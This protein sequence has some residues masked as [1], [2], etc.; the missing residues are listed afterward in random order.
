MSGNSAEGRFSKFWRFTKLTWDGLW[1]FTFKPFHILNQSLVRSLVGDAEDPRLIHCVSYALTGEVVDSWEALR[2]ELPEAAQVQ[3]DTAAIF[4]AEITKRQA[5]LSE[6]YSKLSSDEIRSSPNN[7]LGELALSLFKDLFDARVNGENQHIIT[8]RSGISDDQLKLS[9]A[10]MS[11][12]VGYTV[13]LQKFRHKT[14]RKE[15]WN[16]IRSLFNSKYALL[17]ELSDIEKN[18]LIPILKPAFTDWLLHLKVPQEII[19]EIFSPNVSTLMDETGKP[20][21]QVQLRAATERLLKQNHPEAY[22]L[23]QNFSDSYQESNVPF[24]GWLLRLSQFLIVLL[25]AQ[26][27]KD[28]PLF[29]QALAKSFNEN[30]EQLDD[31][32][33]RLGQVMETLSQIIRYDNQKQLYPLG[34]FGNDVEMLKLLTQADQQKI[35]PPMLKKSVNLIHFVRDL[36]KARREVFSGS[37]APGKPEIKPL[38]FEE[39]CVTFM[40]KIPQIATKGKADWVEFCTE[41]ELPLQ[42]GSA[43][44]SIYALI[45]ERLDEDLFKS[46]RQSPEFLKK[47]PQ[48]KKNYRAIVEAFAEGNLVHAEGLFLDMVDQVIEQYLKD[49]PAD[50]MPALL[51]G[52]YLHVNPMDKEKA[53]SQLTTEQ[54]K[55]LSFK[56][57]E[58]RIKAEPDANLKSMLRK[59]QEGFNHVYTK[60]APTITQG[61]FKQLVGQWIEQLGTEADP[62]LQAEMRKHCVNIQ[63]DAV[64]NVDLTPAYRDKVNFLKSLDYIEEYREFIQAV[65]TMNDYF[66]SSASGRRNHTQS[67]NGFSYSRNDC[68]ARMASWKMV[69]DNLANYL[70]KPGDSAKLDNFKLLDTEIHKFKGFHIPMKGKIDWFNRSAWGWDKANWLTLKGW[71]LDLLKSLRRFTCFRSEYAD[72]LKRL[73]ATFQRLILVKEIQP[74]AAA[75]DPIATLKMYHSISY[76]QL[77]A[78]CP[79]EAAEL[80][81]EEQEWLAVEKERLDAT[82]EKGPMF[83]GKRQTLDSSTEETES[84]GDASDL[85]RTVA[86]DTG[87]VYLE[88]SDHKKLVQLAES[89]ES[90]AAFYEAGYTALDPN[91]DAAYGNHLIYKVWHNRYDPEESLADVLGEAQPRQTA[92]L[93]AAAGGFLNYWQLATR[94]AIEHFDKVRLANG[95]KESSEKP[96][97]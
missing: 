93:Q 37:K 35:V 66:D 12:C 89:L 18:D 64:T 11:L 60:S 52:R 62:H 32:L 5:V 33:N 15:V 44:L 79:K 28:Q 63:V 96:K 47:L 72:H 74:Q 2:A 23:F 7:Q 95:P 19:N 36:L 56:F 30:W 8:L 61:N 24:L 25:P 70:K 49:Q 58:E 4:D 51:L 65:R 3:F 57:C 43:P 38:P 40:E 45:A 86:E 76:N 69:L 50:S 91:Q 22:Q 83:V 16:A 54:K 29:M 10:L 14:L 55:A 78:A 90:V 80:V 46:L 77:K 82:V 68:D 21:E 92:L 84:W 97:L 94:E 41:H 20:S 6:S 42:E 59:L 67:H 85:F 73:R 48:D 87:V 53:R 26:L 39:Q 31:F 81:E 88:T 9:K 75:K 71:C 1:A 34:L 27:D 17:H 13:V